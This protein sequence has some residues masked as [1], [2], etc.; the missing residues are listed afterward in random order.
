MQIMPQGTYN[1]LPQKFN[2]LLCKLLTINTS[3]IY[4]MH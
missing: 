3:Y 2:K 4:L 1:V